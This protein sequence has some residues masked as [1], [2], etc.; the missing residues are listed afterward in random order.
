MIRTQRRAVLLILLL[1]CLSVLLSC[2]KSGEKTLE[3]SPLEL[4]AV[5]EVDGF[6]VPLELYRY[7]ALN[8]K[9]DYEAA[10]PGVWESADM[11][12]KL[13]ELEEKTRETIVRLYA[14]PSLCRQYGIDT[15]DAYIRDAVEAQMQDIYEEMGNDYDAFE[16]YL[17][18]YNL[19]DGVYRFI[20]RNDILAEELL[21]KMVERGEIVSG[22]EELEGIVAGPE[23]VRVKQILVP[24]DNGKSDEENEGRAR[25]LYGMAV[26]GEDFDTL[27]QKYGGDLFMF[28][29][30]DGYYISRGNYH[31]AFEEAAFSLD[32]GEISEIVRTDAG[33]SILKRY[34]KEAGYLADH[35]DDLVNDYMS[36]VYNMKLEAHASALT[37]KP[38]D[39]LAEYT[40]FNLD[41]TY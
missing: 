16:E 24:S 13:A 19:T 30:P 40:V 10:D 26:S 2:Q 17:R 3:S 18:T 14:T 7:V 33:W 39:K 9:A 6:E 38:T 1:L 35:F 28:N 34:E 37:A 5:M 11:S 32:V 8:Y 20:V 31:E 29:N 22:E 41:T 15:D 25:E 23:F 4:T 21:A 36:G 27:V 12:E